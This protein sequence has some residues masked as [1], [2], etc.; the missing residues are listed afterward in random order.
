VLENYLVL[1]YVSIRTRIIATIVYNKG[2]EGMVNVGLI[3][4]GVGGFDEKSTKYPA[5]DKPDE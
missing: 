1:N 3:N 2:R 5:D 4:A